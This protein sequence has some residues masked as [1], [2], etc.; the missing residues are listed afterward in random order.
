MKSAITIVLFTFAIASV[1]GGNAEA[2]VGSYDS[3]GVFRCGYEGGSMEPTG[4][5]GVPRIMAIDE[6]L[7]GGDADEHGCIGS[8]GYTWCA[9]SG[10]CLRVWEEDCASEVNS[11]D[12][13]LDAGFP[14]MESYPRQC[15]AGG[16]TFTESLPG[17]IS[18]MSN[19]P[20][21]G[22]TNPKETVGLGIA[23]MGY[24]PLESLVQ[25]ILGLFN[26]LF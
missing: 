24:S 3:D 14:V 15:S 22:E 18:G 13:C 5:E 23:L 1:L 25:A 2:C 11:F 4:Q 9:A 6:P 7:L 26:G 19:A 20:G 8:A 17:E 12:Q 16:Y 21:S 10:K